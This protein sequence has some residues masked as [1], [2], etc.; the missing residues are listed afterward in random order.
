MPDDR[1]SRYF[2]NARRPPS[3]SQ[4]VRW[5]KVVPS[6]SLNDSYRFDLPASSPVLASM[7]PGR[8]STADRTSCIRT[9][10]SRSSLPT[11][12]ALISFCPV[13]MPVFLPLNSVSWAV[14]E[15]M[16]ALPLSSAAAIDLSFTADSCDPDPRAKIATPA[17]N[18]AVAAAT[19]GFL[20][21][22]MR[23][24]RTSPGSRFVSNRDWPRPCRARP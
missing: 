15:A 9:Q 13:S 5:L 23:S 20:A 7:Y 19:A 16:A 18:A 21:R 24:V 17:R 4:K 14:A 11:T 8:G 22:I 6:P 1:R 2:S 12:I 3:V 10:F